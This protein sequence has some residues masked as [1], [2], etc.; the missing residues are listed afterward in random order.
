MRKALWC[1][2]LAGCYAHDP[3]VATAR[4]RVLNTNTFEVHMD[5]LDPSRRE[6]ALRREGIQVCPGGFGLLS[7]ELS[8]DSGR[9]SGYVVIRC[10]WE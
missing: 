3:Y 8:V 1:L 4:T 2:L 9:L 10:R 6:Y 5:G 7:N